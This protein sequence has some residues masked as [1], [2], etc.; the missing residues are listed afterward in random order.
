MT[1]PTV[2]ARGLDLGPL[3]IRLDRRWHLRL[4]PIVVAHYRPPAG[5]PLVDEARIGVTTARPGTPS[6]TRWAQGRAFRP[7]RL[8]IGI[9]R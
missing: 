8:S 9:I 5:A 4:G 6:V 3:S 7:L 2:P 1:T